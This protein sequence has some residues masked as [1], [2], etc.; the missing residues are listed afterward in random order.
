MAIRIELL[1]SGT[2]WDLYVVEQKEGKAQVLEFID[3]LPSKEANILISFLEVLANTG[4]RGKDIKPFRRVKGILEVRHR[5]LN[6]RFWGCYLKGGP[7]KSFVLIWA[8]KKPKK[9][10]LDTRIAKIL[11]RYKKEIERIGRRG[12]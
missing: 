6:I 1:R 5:G 11:E 8:S 2:E 10:D 7:K 12:S 4:E 3:G 9:R